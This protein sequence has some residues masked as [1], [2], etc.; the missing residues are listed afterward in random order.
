MYYVII[1]RSISRILYYFPFFPEYEFT[2]AAQCKNK[3]VEVE[4][5]AAGA[6]VTLT[7]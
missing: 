3:V 7:L 1:Y 6:P 2:A 5:A 4:A